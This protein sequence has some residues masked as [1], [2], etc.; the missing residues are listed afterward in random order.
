M[1]GSIR[2]LILA[3]ALA[4]GLG[5]AVAATPSLAQ[6]GA[7]AGITFRYTD[8]QGPGCL[9]IASQGDDPAGGGTA[10][11]V[12]LTQNGAS[13]SGQGEEWVISATAPR[14]TALAF[15]LSDGNGSSFFFDGT[16]RMGVDTLNAQGQW[17]SLLDPTMTDQW[18][19]FTMFPARPCTGT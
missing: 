10:I 4:L 1:H 11:S 2:Y 14:T 6:G 16:M 5:A 19:A 18:Q 17:T 8:S 15:W 3:T 12:T 9:T 13:L 7:P